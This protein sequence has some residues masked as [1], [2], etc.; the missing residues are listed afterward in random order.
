[1]FQ[2]SPLSAI[3]AV[4]IVVGSIVGTKVTLDAMLGLGNVELYAS[5]GFM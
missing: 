2:K 5:N 3:L 1:M 4:G